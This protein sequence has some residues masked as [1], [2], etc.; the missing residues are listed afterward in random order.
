MGFLMWGG[1]AVINFKTMRNKKEDKFMKL[2]TLFSILAVS[3]AVIIIAIALIQ[4]N[5]T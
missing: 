1:L 4:I 2:A 3:Y 5:S